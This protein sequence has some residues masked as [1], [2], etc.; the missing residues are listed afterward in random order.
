M[1]GLYSPSGSTWP[2]SSRPSH[3]ISTGPF[4][5]SRPLSIVRTTRSEPSTIATSSRSDCLSLNVIEAVC[6][7]QPQTGEN[8]GCGTLVPKIAAGWFLSPCVSAK[9]AAVAA[10]S[11]TTST[12]EAIRATARAF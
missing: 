4:A 1:R 5:Y 9:A 3:S 8:T 10:S 12:V 11:A 6:G 7:L 2:A